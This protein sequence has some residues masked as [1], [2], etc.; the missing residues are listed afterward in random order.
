L[1]R[2]G[3]IDNVFDVRPDESAVRLQHQRPYRARPTAVLRSTGS[4]VIANVQIV[5][6]IPNTP[7]DERVIE[8][9]R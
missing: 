5:T 3:R 7:Y 6:A 8:M 1:E 9:P 4:D 2:P